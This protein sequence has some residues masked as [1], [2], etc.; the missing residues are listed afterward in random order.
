MIAELALPLYPADRVPVLLLGGVNLVRALGLAG[1]PAIVASSDPDEPAFASRYCHGRWFVPSPAYGN[2]AINAIV[3]LGNRLCA[4][5][6]RRI[7]LMYGSDEWLNLIS[8]HRERL[9]RYFLLL[10]SE[11]LVAESLIEKDRFQSLAR[12]RALPVP[13]TLAWGTGP[14][15]VGSA[16]GAVLVK[17]RSK[18]DWH[19][20]AMRK[21]L[22]DESKALI[23]ASGA[24][25]AADPALADFH[26][27]VTFQEYVAGGDTS[28]WSYHGF[29]D[30]RGVVLASFVGRK[31]RTH[32]PLVGESAFIELG[33]DPAL[34][35]LGREIAARLPL[36]GIFK[37]DFKKD[38]ATGEW[39]LLEINARFN[40]WLYLG[41]CNGLNLVRFAYDYL[42]DGKR[43]V[44]GV[45]PTGARR[46][47]SLS[48]D[49]RAHRVLRARGEITTARWLAS[50]LASRNVYNVFASSDPGPWLSLW[51]NRVARRA[52][53]VPRRLLAHLRP[54]RSTAS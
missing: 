10:L 39:R 47:L 13:R 9:Q 28:L 14:G 34:D 22:F 29:A 30:E 35:A 3:A 52:N 45:R 11:P 46:W 32:P 17:P 2:L 12:R 54:W 36:K 40:L 43:P 8:A 4:V 15:T 49:Y 33:D 41:A 6:G 5:Y 24:E 42:L 19:D 7:P 16:A 38:A 44:A 31:L 53:R 20:S 37:M 25:A 23:Y 50:I 21:R 51:W 18:V 1:I 26:E 48:L 27:Q